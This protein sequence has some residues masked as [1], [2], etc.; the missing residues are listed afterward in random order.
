[1]VWGI[2]H[3]DQFFE[4]PIDDFVALPVALLQALLLQV[5]NRSDLKE[6]FR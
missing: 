6:S 5:C 4:V 3:A 2:L 1:M